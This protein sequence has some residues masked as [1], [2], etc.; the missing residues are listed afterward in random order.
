VTWGA[1]G[2]A[3]QPQDGYWYPPAGG[4]GP[5]QGQG[6]GQQPPAGP[7]PYQYQDQQ[8]WQAGQDGQ[9]APYYP[10]ADPRQDQ[11]VDPSWFHGQGR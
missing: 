7:E 3:G 1:Q 6:Q 2:A 8:Q 10:S 4:P 9:A 5:G 11:Y